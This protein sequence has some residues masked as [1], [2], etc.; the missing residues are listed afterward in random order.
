MHARTSTL[1]LLL[2][3]RSISSFS[4]LRACIQLLSFL[5]YQGFFLWSYTVFDIHGHFIIIIID[6]FNV[7]GRF[8]LSPIHLIS[9]VRNGLDL[10]LS[11]LSVNTTI[12]T[13]LYFFESFENVNAWRRLLVIM[14]I[15]DLPIEVC[16]R[17][18]KNMQSRPNNQQIYI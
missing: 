5:S 9:P 16:P 12:I 2:L 18:S 3:L 11:H 13:Y 7:T 4:S 6:L 1:L 14:M 10:P 17:F 8:Y 15:G